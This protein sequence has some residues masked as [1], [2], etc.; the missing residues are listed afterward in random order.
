MD[1]EL[2]SDDEIRAAIASKGLGNFA[3]TDQ[4][5]QYFRNKLKTLSGQTVETTF[6]VEKTSH[7]STPLSTEVDPPAIR[8]PNSA[9][10]FYVVSIS[11]GMKPLRECMTVIYDSYSDA[12]KAAKDYPGA[13]ISKRFDIHSDAEIFQQAKIEEE[14]IPIELTPI[15]LAVIRESRFNPL[16]SVK[17]KQKNRLRKL[18]ESDDPSQGDISKREISEFIKVIWKNPKHLVSSGD[19]PEIY[20]E[21]MR[22]NI[23][24]CGVDCGNLEFC[25]TLLE[26]IQS[27]KFWEK[28]YPNDP[29][30]K[31]EADK[32]LLMDRYLNMQDGTVQIDRDTSVKTNERVCTL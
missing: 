23:L 12:R 15:E 16:K 21:G 3:I 22:R 19:C 27:D 25:K 2:L 9:G 11:S 13:R 26:I 6:A 30:E 18:L 4:T 32:L 10:G 1:I 7:S 29:I 5:R 24:H 31:R 8:T 20:H 14:P 28:L 17:T